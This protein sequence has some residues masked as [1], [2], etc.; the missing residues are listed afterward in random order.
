[1]VAGEKVVFA[2]QNAKIKGGHKSS[3]I[4]GGAMLAAVKIVRRSV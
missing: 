1:M 4:G 2:R 3:N